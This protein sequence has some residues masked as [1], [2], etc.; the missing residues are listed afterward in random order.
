MP[1]LNSAQKSAVE[2]LEGPLLVLAGPGTGKTQ[3]LSAKVAYILQ[4]ADTNPENILCLTFTEAGASNMR[5]RLLSMVGKGAN[6][7]NIHTYH[8]FGS[9]ILAQYKNYA[10]E[11]S[12]Q[13]DSPVDT[14]TQYKI[15]KEIQ[16]SLPPLDILKSDNVSDIVDT[17]SSVKSARLSAVDLAKISAFNEKSSI[18]INASASPL[19]KKVVP[20]MKFDI[21][22]AQVYQPLLETLL[23]YSSPNPIVGDIER[24]ANYLTRELKQ[25]IDDEQ[26]KEKPS[27]APLT[28]WKN[29]NW[30][31]DG[32]GNYRLKN[33]VS[34]KKLASLANIMEQYDNHLKAE[35]L[36]DFADMIEQ[37][38]RILKEDTGFRLSLSERYQYILLDEFQDTNPSQFELIRLL[39][40]YEKPNIMAV[41]DDDQAIFAFQ[42]ANASN[43]LDFQ[44]AYQ[45]KVIT[46]T[47]NYRSTQEILDTSYKIAQQV[48]D[49]FAKHH[50]IVKKLTAMLDQAKNNPSQLTK[51]ERHEFIASDTEYYWVARQIHE[52]I[53]N[54]ET[55]SEIAII[56]PK[57]KYI[58]PL[59]PYLKA[60]SDINIAYEKR[61]NILEDNIIKNLAEL[62]RFIYE[63]STGKNADYR[64]LKVLSNSSWGLDPVV[65]I[66]A[67]RDVRA[68]GR[69]ALEVLQKSHNAPLAQV[70]SFLATLVAESFNTPLE[71]MFSYMLG[72]AELDGCPVQ[73]QQSSAPTSDDI[74]YTNYDSFKLYELL[75]VLREKIKSHLNT[76]KLKLEDF[77]NFLDDYSAAGEAIINTSPY[78]DSENSVQIM[79]A[80]KSKGLEFK[81]VFLV[82]TDNLSWGK[83]KGNNNLLALPKNLIQIRHT[84]ITDDEHLRLF[85]VAITR[86]KQTLTI[87]NSK[88][89]YS[90]K[91]PGRLEYLEEYDSED[92]PIS[93]LIPSQKIIVHDSDI[94]EDVKQKGIEYQWLSA[95]QNYTP[96][97]R[98]LFEHRLANYRLSSTDLTT[99]VDIVYAGPMEFFKRKVL[100]S[101]PEPSTSAIVFGNLIHSA[102][103]AVTS[104]HLSD[105]EAI[106]FYNAEVANVPLPES[107]LTNLKDRGRLTLETSLKTFSS[108][109]RSP[110]SKAEVNFEPE[111]LMLDNIPLTGKIDH[112]NL[113][114]SQ[115]TIEVYDFKTGNYHKQAWESHATLYKYKLQLEF[116]KLLLNLS[117]TYRNYTV[118]QGHILFVSPDPAD[119][120]VYDKPYEYTKKSADEFQSLLRSVYR[121]IKSLDFIEKDS[122]LCLYPDS[123]RKLKDIKDF[124]SLLIANE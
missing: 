110:D 27:V 73:F 23:E 18:K 90:G 46:L 43:L 45:S 71:Q 54:G 10:T 20:R 40:D 36:F 34:N 79:T 86:A 25:I 12:R 104:K 117:P 37:A 13:L 78:Q 29:A 109:L 51:I 2:Y 93:P 97:L 60:Y 108:I 113:N 66:S 3:L 26:V 121:H 98:P 64:L 101:L 116:Y 107:D 53:K 9:N 70:A 50:G 77:I 89:D 61:E 56:T 123:T 124:V 115:K 58:A 88:T 106:E 72:L 91:T 81:H 5:D 67:L 17:I 102:F 80:H 57:H 74:D 118:T 38:I 8:A 41:G 31:L 83:A 82:A 19:L 11:F 48:D 42:G 99:F 111:H 7:V 100:Y 21:A 55:Q 14:V 84:G 16:A 4:H 69:P 65:V 39:T 63:T 95:Y 62:S 87:T 105:A 120:A 6:Q 15:I 112:L 1:Q 122:P 92:G 49:S 119:S 103:E 22:L 35:G 94:P 30:E 114:P 76:E 32:N 52:L 59:L 28:K 68:T 75:S 47:E 33:V 24:E 96:A 44:N 85:F